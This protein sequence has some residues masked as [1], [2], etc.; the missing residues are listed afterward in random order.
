MW[1]PF[2]KK[3]KS[4]TEKL[5]QHIKEIPLEELTGLFDK[6][7][8]LSETNNL[9]TDLSRLIHP[10]RFPNDEVKRREAENLFKEVQSN[11]TDKSKLIELK[12][13][14]ERLINS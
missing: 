11:R 13:K 8:N 4:D 6:L 14:A 10:D 3:E 7:N 2:K 12:K 1:N 9:Y 5:T